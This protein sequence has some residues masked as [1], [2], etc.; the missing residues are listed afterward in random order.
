MAW[1][2]SIVMLMALAASVG[3][4]AQRPQLSQTHPPG[5][6]P[7]LG[8]K[9]A[10][11]TGMLQYR[12]RCGDCHGLDARGYRGPDLSAAIAGGVTDERLFQTIRRG[13]P[14]TEMP[15]STAPDDDVLMII[16]YLRN[17]NA[18]A[19]ENRREPQRRPIQTGHR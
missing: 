12:V 13:V 6:N 14:G 5:K 3:L 2:R 19:P 15:P 11:R 8:D 10:I 9:A 18:S 17:M 4:T 7:H 1:T 16:A